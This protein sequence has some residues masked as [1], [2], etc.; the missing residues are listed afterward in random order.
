VVKTRMENPA[1][2]LGVS[3]SV[4]NLILSPFSALTLSV[5]RQEWHPTCRSLGVGMSMV[6]I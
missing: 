6:T 3:K 4:W 5:G 1:G 2:E